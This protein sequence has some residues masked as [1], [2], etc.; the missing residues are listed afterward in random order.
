MIKIK[1]LSKTFMMNQTHLKILKNITLTVLK[2]EIFGLVGSSGSGKSTLLKIMNEFIIPDQNMSQ[3]MQK[4]FNRFESAMIFQNF[5][6]LNNLNVFDNIALPLKIRKYRKEL[7]QKEVNQILTFVG[8]QS[9]ANVYP[10]TLSG[11]QK[12]RIAIARALIYKPKIVFC[13]EPT[14]AL[15][16]ITSQEILCLL[17]KTNQQLKTTIFLV[18]HN[19]AVIK[20]LCHRV[21]IL[22]QGKLEKIVALNPTYKM[23]AVPYQNIF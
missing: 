8:L 1:N 6:L 20:S 16:E 2:G 5:N 18:S 13:D 11:G 4:S 7:I 9:F 23:E 15:D 12:Q 14:F 3:V 19:V 17:L 22:H 10:K 21:A